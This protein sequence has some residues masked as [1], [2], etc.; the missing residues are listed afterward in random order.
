MKKC[1][2]GRYWLDRHH[3]VVHKGGVDINKETS[4]MTDTTDKPRLPSTSK[5]LGVYRKKTAPKS[6]VDRADLLM[7]KTWGKHAKF[8]AVNTTRVLNG[9]TVEGTAVADKIAGAMYLREIAVAEGDVGL[10]ELPLARLSSIIG[11]V[12]RRYDFTPL[13]IE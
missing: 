12:L 5:E 1:V 8:Q 4:I 2:L 6:E 10:A 13:A 3:A 7:Q 9:S 11:T